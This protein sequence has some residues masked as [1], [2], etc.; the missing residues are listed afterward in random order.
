MRSILAV[1]GATALFIGFTS[2]GFAAEPNPTVK[3]FLATCAKINALDGHTP[4]HADSDAYVECEDTVTL[5]VASMG[6]DYCAPP[7]LTQPEVIRLA[8]IKWLKHRPRMFAK[9]E[10]VAIQAALKALYCH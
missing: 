8:V 7:Q 1:A 9:D 10:V 6:N 4:H 2:F 3:S 5:A